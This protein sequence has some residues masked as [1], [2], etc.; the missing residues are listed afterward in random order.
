MLSG[1]S[2]NRPSLNQ[3]PDETL[4]EIRGTLDKSIIAPR[5]D[6]V[7]SSSKRLEDLVEKVVLQIDPG[8]AGLQTEPSEAVLQIDPGE[9]GLQ[10]EPSE[11]V[12]QIDPGEARL[13]IDPGEARL[14]TEPS[15][16]G[17]ETDPGEAGLQTD[18]GEAGLQ[19]EPSEARLQTDPGEAE[20]QTEPS[21]ARLQTS[22]NINFVL[23]L[24]QLERLDVNGAVIL[25]RLLR[26]CSSKQLRSIEDIEILNADHKYR[27]LLSMTL[28]KTSPVSIKKK[29]H[30]QGLF[31]P[32]ILTC[33][34]MFLLNSLAFCGRAGVQLWRDMCEITKTLG[35][36]TSVLCSWI[37]KPTKIYGT[38]IV[39]QVQRMS[40]EAIPT[41]GLMSFLVGVVITKQ[42]VSYLGRFGA[43][44]YVI[45]MVSVMMLREISVLM[46][47]VMVAGRTGSAIT[48][49]LGSMKMREEINAI[50]IIGLNP[51]EVLVLPRILALI[52]S[53]PVLVFVSYICALLGEMLVCSVYLGTSSGL[54]FS[55]FI[56][57]V[58][59]SDFGVGMLKAVCMAIAIAVIATVE[60]FR[61]TGST[62]SLGMHT[63]LSVV[64]S[65][66]VI[67]V[68]DA[69]FSVFFTAVGI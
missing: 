42:G 40:I 26:I 59:F 52:A 47:A 27:L 10:T 46:T 4:L 24:K 23:D 31:S 55:T 36:A 62:E 8:E 66:F 16:A 48:A 57:A 19:T 65:I 3:S 34:K 32:E 5:G 21:E 45:D 51:T 53:L 25:T 17:L 15:E 12:L 63:T 37:I 43:E 14:Q 50:K 20:L 6:W 18:P 44:M 41:I 49:E 61:G 35:D 60:A 2:K 7:T 11:A 67:V 30:T 56:D 1:L 28:S 38:A 22:P 58:V 54:F 29:D 33:G 13:Q 68:T 69:F 39:V 9:A 64:K